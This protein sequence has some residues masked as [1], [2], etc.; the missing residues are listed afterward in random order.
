MILI[1]DDTPENL[2]SLKRVLEKHDFEVDTA[3]SGEEALKKVLRNAYV[4]IILDVQ[5]PG[6]DGYELARR[7]RSQPGMTNTTLIATTGYGDEQGRKEAFA[8][9]FDH[10]FTKPIDIERLFA[11]LAEISAA[12]CQLV[13]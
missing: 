12:N 11:L 7:L 4:L 6:M 2:I 1:V 10:H 3:S 5:M 13:A 9:G 8:A